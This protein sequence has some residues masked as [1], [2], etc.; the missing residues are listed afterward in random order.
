MCVAHTFPY[1][2]SV[3][4]CC[5]SAQGAEIKT[6]KGQSAAGLYNAGRTSS[7]T[8]DAQIHIYRNALAEMRRDTRADVLS[9]YCKDCISDYNA[10][11]GVHSSHFSA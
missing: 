6:V 3:C 8:K 7:R 4:V 11:D 9:E 1:P 5:P 2:Y 10:H